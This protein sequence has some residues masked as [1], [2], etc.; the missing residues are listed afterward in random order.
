MT[1]YEEYTLIGKRGFSLNKIIIYFF[2]IDDMAIR[3]QDMYAVTKKI[4]WTS[5]RR[6][7]SM[8]DKFSQQLDAVMRWI[9]TRNKPKKNMLFN[10]ITLL[11]QGQKDQGDDQQWGCLCQ[12]IFNIIVRLN[13]SW[14]REF[15]A[16]LILM[17][18]EGYINMR[19]IRKN[20]P[21]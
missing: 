9:S 18:I 19:Y 6:I 14:T 12:L 7:Y 10:V 8:P 4:I 15:S 13:L 20:I 11:F 16:H 2:A 5:F 3:F 17:C 21:K 1:L